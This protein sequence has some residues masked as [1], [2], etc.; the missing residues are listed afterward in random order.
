MNSPRPETPPDPDAYANHDDAAAAPDPTGRGFRDPGSPRSGLIAWLALI[1]LVTA[2]TIMQWSGGPEARD[3]AA[4]PEGPGGITLLMGRYIVGAEQLAPSAGRQTLP[5]LESLAATPAAQLQL[6]IV[7]AE[8]APAPEEDDEDEPTP[9]ERALERIDGLL[10][11][12]Q[13]DTGAPESEEP[14]DWLL[15]D[16]AALRTI[17]TSGPAALADHARDR[18]IERYGWFARLA[19]TFDERDATAPSAERTALLSDATR[20]VMVAVVGIALLALGVLVGFALL[21]I[22]IIRRASGALTLRYAPPAPGGSVYLEAFVV[23]MLGFFIVSIASALI[24]GLTGLDLTPLLVWL[25][26]L[27]AFWPRLRGAPRPA[28]RFA[29]G[30]HAGAGVVREIGAGVIGYIAALPIFALGVLLTVILSAAA[31]FFAGPSGEP[32]P[33]PTHPIL[34]DIIHGGLWHVAGIYLLAAVWAPL[35]EETLFRGSLFH[36]F[37]GRLGPIS[38]ALLV[39]FIFAVIHPQGFIAVPALMSLGFSFALLREWRG[40]LIAPIVAHALHNGALIT[41]LTLALR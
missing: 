30:W 32:A 8:V 13:Q 29:L 10:A 1:A 33:P 31:S 11:S 26:L 39:G 23:F 5:Q 40:S 21:I 37:R 4:P 38:A 6:A 22:A 25:L 15:E 12:Y 14:P 16:A 19:L 9:A 27:A 41:A 7:A 20:V 24:T 17:Y 3:P 18:L 36:H 28:W 35:V 2:T 34:D